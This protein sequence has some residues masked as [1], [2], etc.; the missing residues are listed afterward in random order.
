M[1]DLTFNEFAKH[2]SVPRTTV[3]TKL[4]QIKN[5]EPEKYES[6]VDTTK[7]PLKIRAAYVV[8]LEQ[9]FKNPSAPKE[10]PKQNQRS[11]Q[12][13]LKYLEQALEESEERYQNLFTEYTQLVRHMQTVNQQLMTLMMDQMSQKK[14]H[15]RKTN[16]EE[17]VG[18]MHLFQD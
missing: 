6:Y 13:E 14:S 1:K 8:A 18:Q 3:Y 2:I 4:N 5:Q 16:N 12:E 10:T 11:M 15:P 9:L 7:E 17:R